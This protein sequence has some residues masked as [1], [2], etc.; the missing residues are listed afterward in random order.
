MRLTMNIRV[1]GEINDLKTACRANMSR[2]GTVQAANL[3][4]AVNL[5]CRTGLFATAHQKAESVLAAFCPGA[6]THGR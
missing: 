6:S 2:S 4:P 1:A 3:A 5:P